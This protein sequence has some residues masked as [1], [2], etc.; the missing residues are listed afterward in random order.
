MQQVV[1]GTVFLYTLFGVSA[2]V[3]MACIPLTSPIGVWIG[4]RIYGEPL[5][6]MS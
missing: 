2:F 3:G 6:E 1:I 5:A 4:K